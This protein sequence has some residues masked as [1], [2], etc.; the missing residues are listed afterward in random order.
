M[1]TNVVSKLSAILGCAVVAALLTACGDRGPAQ[2]TAESTPPATS[3]Q[4]ASTQTPE[5]PPQT[6]TASSSASP[7]SPASTPTTGKPCASPPPCGA[8]CS[9]QP[10]EPTDCWT[11]AYGPAKADVLTSGTNMLYCNGGA[12]ALC[13]F[14]GP[15][16]PTGINPHNQAL[17]CELKG[18]VANCTC[19]VYTSGANFVDINAIL[20]RG[21]YYET[22]NACGAD[23]SKCQTMTS[24]GPDG[25]KA[26][27][28]SLPPA[29]VC[30]YV[31]NQSPTNPS[32]SLM[33]KA[34]LDSTF[35]F[36]MV[37]D[38]PQSPHPPSCSGLYA[39]CMTAP[40]FFKPGHTGSP[41]DGEPIQCEC[42]TYTGTYQVGATNQA[43]TIPNQGT[44]SYVWSA[45][46]NVPAGTTA[47]VGQ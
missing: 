1:R 3:D 42:P 6:T 31:K 47:P 30:Q 25:K 22:V 29:P 27:C 40:C 18:D 5:A 10:F 34:D 7:G 37:K 2:G 13:F 17:P 46:N 45:G 41:V 15:P 16:N 9:N 21:A 35:S 38:H 26:G 20:N 14:S 36:A 8:H 24:C 19:Q 44:T 4:Q 32:V 28:G 11:T 12:Y 43:C 39:G 33:P 23:G